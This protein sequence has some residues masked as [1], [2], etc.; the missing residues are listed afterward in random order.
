MLSGWQRSSNLLGIVCSAVSRAVKLL[1]DQNLSPKLPHRLR[2]LFAGSD[3]VQ[4]ASLD[5]AD[6]DQVWE[7]ARLHG[8]AI[9]RKDEDF[10]N[11][12]ALRGSTSERRG[13]RLNQ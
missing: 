5:R 10:D 1:F 6:D 12:A 2:D 9:V 3:H 7:H 8:F 11:L 13:K 4:S